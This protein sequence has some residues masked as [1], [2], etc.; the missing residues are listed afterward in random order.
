VA[1]IQLGNG[2]DLYTLDPNE[3]AATIRGGGGNDRITGGRFD[4]FLFGDAGDDTLLG[5]AGDDTLVGGAGSN[6]YLGGIGV[7]VAA[8]D[9]NPGDYYL[10]GGS[11]DGVS[12]SA[13]LGR[14]GSATQ[15][16]GTD[17]EK[18]Q[19]LSGE[20]VDRGVAFQG[21]ASGYAW[22]FNT[23]QGD[24]TLRAP[25]LIGDSVFNG[26]SGNNVV[27]LNGNVDDYTLSRTQVPQ[28][29]RATGTPV[30]G[31]FVL[32][33]N[34]GSGSYTFDESVDTIRFQNGQALSLEHLPFYV[35]GD[36]TLAAGGQQDDFFYQTLSR[37]YEFF[38]GG[39]GDTVFLKGNVQD[40]TLR[41]FEN[42][43]TI[44]GGGIG[45]G[46]INFG[47]GYQKTT[48]LELVAKNGGTLL[49]VSPDMNVVFQNG[50]Q[51]AY[52]DVPRYVQADANTTVD[53]VAIGYDMR[54][55]FDLYATTYYGVAGDTRALLNGN[56]EDYTL[57]RNF[58]GD[59]VLTSKSGSRA[60]DAV[61]EESVATVFFGNGQ[62]LSLADLPAYV[63]GNAVFTR[64]P[65]DG[66]FVARD[67]LLIPATSGDQSLIGN[68]GTDVAYLNGSAKDYQGKAIDLP[69][70]DGFNQPTT[71]H[72][73]ELVGLNGS[74][75]LFIDDSVETIRFRDGQAITFR[76]L[77]A[78]VAPSPE[79]G[80]AGNDIFFADY[81]GDQYF[82]GGAGQ[83][84]AYIHGN[85]WDYRIAEVNLAA[86]P[87]HPAVQG[88]RLI[89]NNGSGDIFIDQSTEYTVFQ[90]NQY[91]SFEHLA[92][93]IAPAIATDA[94][95]NSLF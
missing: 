89:G 2:D 45:S 88:Y 61:I 70:V 5:G 53:H 63:S 31:H 79:T 50:Q 82:N 75:N 73:F 24:Y 62:Y 39:A 40:Y 69:A 49:F 21:I 57:S 56:V 47:G 6:Y 64:A 46:S 4:D 13:L 65:S 43:F 38:R 23:V 83:D 7:D 86:T 44:P 90:N 91:L 35:R 28:S 30:P 72:G 80:S 76:E 27:I 87:D 17:V 59:F 3:P 71:L 34:N 95:D 19:F 15:F 16:I 48:G 42:T 25:I 52:A 18:I 26:G 33:R 10:A 32:T 9:G 78:V 94:A 54:A 41:S 67:D 29:A 93:F 74:G 20:K 81:G 77:A 8:L 92:S 1:E 66:Y 85:V 58:V 37:G 60:L 51:L 68:G 14:D 11:R 12:Y 22:S 55:G 36:P 84:L